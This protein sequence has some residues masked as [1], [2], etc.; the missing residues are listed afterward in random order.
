MYLPYTSL[1]VFNF[2]LSIIVGQYNI[3]GAV[4]HCG[5]DSLGIPV[6][7]R[8]FTHIQNGPGAKPAFCTMGTRSLPVNH[9]PHIALRINKEYK[10]TSIAPMGPHGLL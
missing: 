5:L 8:F 6:R 1:I 7:T 3:V 9:P 10:C 4:T 2:P